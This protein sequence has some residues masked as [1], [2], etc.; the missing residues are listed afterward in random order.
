MSTPNVQDTMVTQDIGWVVEVSSSW[1]VEMSSDHSPILVQAQYD[2][3]C[4][5]GI[6]YHLVLYCRLLPAGPFDTVCQIDKAVISANVSS[7]M[8][9]G[10]HALVSAHPEVVSHS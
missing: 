6:F 5:E 10:S 1:L 7:T 8:K 2:L 4:E 3:R 9:P